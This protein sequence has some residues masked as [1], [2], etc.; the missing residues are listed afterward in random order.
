MEIFISAKKLLQFLGLLDF[1]HPRKKIIGI[2]LNTIPICFL[3]MASLSCLCFFRFEANNYFEKIQSICFCAAIFILLIAYCVLLWERQHVLELIM[4][5]EYKINERTSLKKIIHSIKL[6]LLY[7]WDLLIR[8][9]YRWKIFDKHH[10]HNDKWEIW[11]VD[12]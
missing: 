3:S 4:Q 7:L 1:D 12:Q 11:K 10:L 6:I 5:F 8:Y 2:V 9:C